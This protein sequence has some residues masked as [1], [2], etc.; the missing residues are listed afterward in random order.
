MDLL[1]IIVETFHADVNIQS[2]SEEYYKRET[3]IIQSATAI[4][5]LAGSDYWWQTEGVRYLLQHGADPDLCDGKGESPLHIALKGGYRR[6]QMV[7]IL[8]EGGANPNLVDE[9]GNTPLGL[10]AGNAE[11]VRLLLKHGA[12]IH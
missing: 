3:R 11:L 8:L 4:G 1:K 2:F 10:A 12:D 6:N 7:K 5:V 9:E